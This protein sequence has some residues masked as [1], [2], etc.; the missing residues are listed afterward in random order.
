MYR[1]L[2]SLALCLLWKVYPP[3]RILYGCV[4][5]GM[6]EK[7]TI[8]KNVLICVEASVIATIGINLLIYYITD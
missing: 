6:K 2:A 7:V 5:Y 4:F 3:I 1:F 8:V